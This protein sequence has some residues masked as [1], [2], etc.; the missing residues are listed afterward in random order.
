MISE[1]YQLLILQSYTRRLRSWIESFGIVLAIVGFILIY[2][3]NGFFEP[4]R[5]SFDAYHLQWWSVVGYSISAGCVVA[6]FVLGFLVPSAFRVDVNNLS[7]PNTGS[8]NVDTAIIERVL[9]KIQTIETTICLL[10]S[11]PA[12]IGAL[13]FSIGRPHTVIFIYLGISLLT[14]AIFMP[15]VSQTERIIEK[16]IS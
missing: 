10:A 4:L 16:L 5:K 3:R 1:Q 15:S 6:S 14:G 9:N 12:L 7:N 2:D 8:E 13:L 11:C